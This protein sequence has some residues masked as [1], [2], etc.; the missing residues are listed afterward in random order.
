MYSLLRRW[1]GHRTNAD[2]PTRQLLLLHQSVVFL[3]RQLL[4]LRCWYAGLAHSLFY[5]LIELI[6]LC[7][8]WIWIG[9]LRWL[10][11]GNARNLILHLSLLLAIDGHTTR[12]THHAAAHEK[13]RALSLGHLTLRSTWLR[14]LHDARLIALRLPALRVTNGGRLLLL[15]RLEAHWLLSFSFFLIWW[16]ILPAS[17]VLLSLMLSYG[18]RLTSNRLPGLTSILLLN[19]ILLC[20]CLLRRLSLLHF[21]IF[22]VRGLMVYKSCS[23][24]SS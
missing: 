2:V 16:H 4:H 1:H 15:L 12:L 6:Q 11:D 24:L 13:V 7:H 20:S 9:A 18:L 5:W 21:L 8:L 3:R 10:W 17:H 22:L 23:M 19:L 14:V